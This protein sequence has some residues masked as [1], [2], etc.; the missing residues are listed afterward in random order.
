MPTMQEV[1]AKFPQYD[2]LSDADL[3][4][5]LHR[6]YYADMPE[7]DFQKRIGYTPPE[8]AAS[9]TGKEPDPLEPASGDPGALGTSVLAGGDSLLLG[10]GNEIGA[11]L[12][13]PIEAAI[14][15]YTGEDEGKSLTQRIMDGYN[16]GLRKRDDLMAYAEGKHPL[17]ATAGTVAGSVGAGSAMA[18]AGLSVAANT[19]ARGGNLA[20]VAA[21]SAA[22]GA[23]MG[24]IAGAGEGEGLE[25]RLA[26]ARDGALIG[27]IAGGTI[28]LAVAGA[29]AV[30][31]P[32][33]N[34]VTARIT[35]QPFADKAL[36]TAMRR[37]NAT[38]ES[39]ARQLEEAQAAG[40]DAFTVADALGNS[41]QRM[42]NVVTR[43]P[44][45]A[46]Q[47]AVEFLGRRQ[48][49]AG[50]RVA[51]ALTDASGSPMS[52]A[53]YTRTLEKL[54]QTE[55]GINY[56]PVMNETAPINVNGAIGNANARIS[57]L[58]DQFARSQ[59]AVPTDLAI[60]APIEAGEAQIRDP[61]RE[62]LKTARSYLASD[63]LTVTNVSQAFRAKTNIDAMIASATANGRGGEVNALLPVQ[64]AL[65]EALARTSPTYASARDAYSAASARVDA[66]E[67][68][69]GMAKPRTRTDDS[70]LAFEQ[71]PDDAARAAARVGY[72]DP[73]IAAAEASTG[74][75]S[76]AARPFLSNSAR[77]ELPAFAA[78]GT[79]DDLMAR[80]GR[81]Q[82]MFETAAS[83]TGGSKTADNLADFEDFANFD[84]AVVSRLLNRDFVGAGLQAL[85]KMVNEAK[86]LPPRVVEQVA[87]GLLETNPDA[88][89]KIL[90]AANT[91]ALSDEGRRNVVIGVLNSISSQAIGRASA[92]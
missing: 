66:V 10:W 45:D 26:G 3:A 48:G 21:G 30:T 39:I 90:T 69:K 56:A 85:T 9:P 13:T 1:R 58:A 67:A 31:A 55:A 92:P 80:L 81:E 14:G 71:L 86:G 17:A 51:A 15:L 46:R 88:A 61:I 35:P 37:S 52:A 49:D 22:D 24:G 7:A 79:G 11:A 32:I 38:P 16:R 57:P 5:A 78:P 29:G 91:K 20:R 4:S 34:I 27:G 73:K 64:Q 36:G 83:A 41:G 82:R 87:Q 53:E 42:L 2:D 84:P 70:L 74:N 59:G 89:R 60:R 50:R 47:G 6:K 8:V 43:T 54:R 18:K 44:N 65:D 12:G 75:M 77:R 68:G 25:G 72:F 28:P 19:M 76:N 40:Q 63:N 23:I 62:A 33:R